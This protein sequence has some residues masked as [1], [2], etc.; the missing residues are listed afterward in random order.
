MNEDVR[1]RAI[2]LL[3]SRDGSLRFGAA[4]LPAQLVNDTEC[5]RAPAFMTLWGLVSDGLAYVDTTQPSPDN[6]AWGLSS[7]GRRVA[8]GGTWEPADR[9]GFKRR[10]LCEAPNVDPDEDTARVHLTIAGGYLAKLTALRDH[11]ERLVTTT[12]LPVLGT[13]P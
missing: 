11:F 9:D 1:R 6:W 2:E 4:Y 12:E 8:A 5:A 7:A 10:L 13:A 3:A